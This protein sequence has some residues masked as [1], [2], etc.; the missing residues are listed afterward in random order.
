MENQNESTYIDKLA[1]I[2]IKDKRILS[3]RSRG[4]DV[5][6]TPG[7]K[8]EQGETDK[9]AL[10]REVQEE[11]SVRILHEMIRHIGTYEAQAHGKSE[12]TLVRMTCYTSDFEGELQA[13]AEIEELAWFTHADRDKV[14]MVDVLIYDDLHQRGLIL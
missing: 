5:Y 10:T 6:Y 14:S 7:G 13:A 11:L 12:G 2:Y 9:Q 1:W 3:T 4:K 8:R